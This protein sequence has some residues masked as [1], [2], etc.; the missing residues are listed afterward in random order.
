MA[1]LKYNN[2]NAG[3]HDEKYIFDSQS[4]R[5]TPVSTF[6]VVVLG[7]AGVGKTSLINRFCHE[8]FSNTYQSTIGYPCLSNNI[9]IDQ[10]AVNLKLW[11][12]NPIKTTSMAMFSALRLL[13][14]RPTS[15]YL[16]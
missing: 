10:K 4:V 6:K 12:I 2:N 14:P 15:Y 13:V 11:E 7:H 8:V 9:T 16:N 5:Q 3:Y 1:L